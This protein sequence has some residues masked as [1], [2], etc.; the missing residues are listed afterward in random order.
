VK[1]PGRLAESLQR[2]QVAGRHRVAVFVGLLAIAISRA[3]YLLMRGRFFAEEATAYF[4]HAKRGSA[5]FIGDHVGYIYAFCNASAW[6]AA[7][8]PLEQAPLVTAWLSLGVVAAIVWAA[9]SL[10]SILL[11][12]AG[13]RIAAAALLVV[14]PLAMPVAWLNT[15]NIQVYL[16]ILALLLLFVDLRGLRRTAVVAIAASLLLAGL[17]GLYAAILAPLFVVRAVRERTRRQTLLAGV[18]SLCALAQLVVVQNEHA[19]GNLAEGR[20]S[21]RGVSVLTRDVAAKHVITFLLGPS[22]AT[23]LHRHSF[24]FAGLFWFGLFAVV[25]AVILVAVLASVPRADV[26]FLLVGAFVLVEVLVLFGT[27]QGAGGRYVVVPVAI[28]LL[29]VVHGT[30]ARNHTSAAIASTLCVVTFVAGLSAF[31]TN[32]PSKLRCRNCPQWSHEVRAWESGRTN[33][34]EIWPYWLKS[35]WVITLPHHRPEPANAQRRPADESPR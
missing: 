32:E 8:V 16:G 12:T 15:T 28:L 3:P 1:V 24:S 22:I 30:T 29:I 7:R 9:L 4:V 23:R 17:S 33:Q 5:W 10:P 6:L 25:V 31:W 21:F 19:T 26:A 13:T 34:L 35:R 20:G 14:G 18:I 2:E 27:R 11:P